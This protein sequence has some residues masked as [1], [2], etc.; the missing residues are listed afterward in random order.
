MPPVLRSPA[1][2]STRAP[3]AILRS[4]ESPTA[5]DLTPHVDRGGRNAKARERFLRR[6]SK[7]IVKDRK[8][9]REFAKQ[10]LGERDRS[11]K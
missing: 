2:T 1:R 11:S 5:A 3:G 8:K 10:V 4:L 9:R 7:M 6:R